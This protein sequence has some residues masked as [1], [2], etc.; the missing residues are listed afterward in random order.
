VAGLGVSSLYDVKA[1][2][3]PY[4]VTPSAFLMRARRLGLLDA[5]T[6]RDY[7]ATLREEF[8]NRPKPK[9]RQPKPVNAL[10]KYNSAEYSRSL[11]KQM[12]AKRLPASEITRVLF[13]N[14]RSVSLNEYRATL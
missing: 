7:M 10:R 1:H 2:A 13:Q 8:R 9:A 3:D 12:D 5:A 4:C 14:R 11:L 6:A